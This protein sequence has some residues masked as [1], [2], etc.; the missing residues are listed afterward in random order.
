MAAIHPRQVSGQ[1]GSLKRPKVSPGI[2][3]L[4]PGG[5]IES[6]LQF[7]YSLI[8]W[9]SGGTDGTGLRPHEK[10]APR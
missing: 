4:D 10:V 3:F 2:R 8:G 9:T 6:K 7:S 5:G 1:G